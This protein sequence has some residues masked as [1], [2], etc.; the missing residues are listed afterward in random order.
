MSPTPARV[1]SLYVFGTDRVGD[2]LGPPRTRISS[3]ELPPLSLIG[4]M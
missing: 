2:L 4:M 1:V 3:D